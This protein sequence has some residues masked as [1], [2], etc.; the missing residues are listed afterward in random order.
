MSIPLLYVEP[1]TPEA[2]APYGWV[3]G[4]QST[5][6]GEDPYFQSQSLSIWREHLFDAGM[7]NETEILWTWFG[8]PSDL[9]QQLEA[10]HLTQQAIVPLTAPLI[11]IVAASEPTGHPNMNSLRAFEIPVGMGICIRPWCWHTTRAFGGTATALMLSRRSTSFD[12]IV[13]LQTGS[14][15]SE[16]TRVPVCPRRVVHSSNLTSL[17][18]NSV[19]DAGTGSEWRLPVG[20]EGEHAA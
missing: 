8:D 6:S 11:Q 5:T 13:H 19:P 1:L 3:L 7:A 2:F 12:L 18:A 16:S 10:R 17:P 15:L 4:K 9:V 20:T 14:P